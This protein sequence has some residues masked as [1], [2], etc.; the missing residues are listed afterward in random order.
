MDFMQIKGK[1][2]FAAVKHEIKQIQPHAAWKG[3]LHADSGWAYPNN[4]H[5]KR[6]L[7]DVK[8]NYKK[9]KTRATKLKNHI[10]KTYTEE[11]LYNKFT[12]MVDT[13]T[14]KARVPHLGIQV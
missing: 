3:V 13:T 11:K 14:K 1:N 7:R 6:L 4:E 12:E 9:W 5:A 2:M 10:N 8:S